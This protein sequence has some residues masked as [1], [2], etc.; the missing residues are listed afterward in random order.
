MAWLYLILAGV[1]EISFTTAMRYTEGFTRFWPCVIVLLFAAVSIYFVTKA[2]ELVPLGT[3][4]AAW[5]GIG[6]LGTVAIGVLYFDE[7]VTLWR[8]VFVTTLI[9]SIVG[10]KLVTE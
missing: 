3:A 1:F 4:Y 10:L 2:A 6:A 5:G 8:M 9:L 7:P